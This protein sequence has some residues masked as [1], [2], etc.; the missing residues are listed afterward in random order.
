[1]GAEYELRITKRAAKQ[2]EKGLEHQ[3]QLRVARAIDALAGNP[4]SQGCSKVRA[5]PPGT[6]RI[7]VGDFRIVYV[8]RDAERAIIVVRIARRSEATYR[9]L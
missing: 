4:R 2:L 3:D 5:A 6:F 9:D 1:V 7:R 8:V